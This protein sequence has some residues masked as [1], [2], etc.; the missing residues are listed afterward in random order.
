M[1]QSLG[2][3]DEEKAV[4]YLDKIN[5]AYS[6]YIDKQP[7]GQEVKYDDFLSYLY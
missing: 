2:E 6:D 3:E 7:T 1:Y 5:R 4:Q